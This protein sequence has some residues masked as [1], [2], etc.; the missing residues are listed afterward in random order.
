MTPHLLHLIPNISYVIHLVPIYSFDIWFFH[1]Y[2]FLFYSLGTYYL[3]QH[4][5]DK[6]TINPEKY[7]KQFFEFIE[8]QL[9]SW[10]TFL[11]LIGH[12]ACFWPNLYDFVARFIKNF[13]HLFRGQSSCD[14]IWSRRTLHVL[15]SKNVCLNCSLSQFTHPKQPFITCNNLRILL[16]I[17]ICA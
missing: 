3:F 7:G 13:F 2:F 9:S 1:S 11:A 5:E 10:F 6:K 16:N 4:D 14:L 17:L 15:N 12:F 8:K